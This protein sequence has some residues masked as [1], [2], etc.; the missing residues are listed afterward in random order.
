MTAQAFQQVHFPADQVQ[1]EVVGPVRTVGV[2]AQVVS[3]AESL[4]GAEGASLVRCAR[5]ASS[6]PLPQEVPD[7]VVAT[8]AGLMNATT[9]LGPYAGWEWTK[10]GIVSRW[11][12]SGWPGMVLF[13]SNLGWHAWP[14]DF[15]CDA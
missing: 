14:H 6:V 12:A 10:S 2:L 13:G 7:L 9:D 11:G 15:V 8:P 4:R 5:I 1:W 3:F